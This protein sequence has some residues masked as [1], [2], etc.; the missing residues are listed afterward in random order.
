MK[1]KATVFIGSRWH[2]KPIE[3]GVHR[4][5]WLALAMAKLN[6][7]WLDWHTPTHYWADGRWEACEVGIWWEVAPLHANRK[8]T[9]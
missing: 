8:G 7:M 6:A 3:C 4:W 5:L 9:T 1:W 2:R